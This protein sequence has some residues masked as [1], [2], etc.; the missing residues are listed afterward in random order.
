MEA[1][2]FFDE[3]D[4]AF[5]VETP[6]GNLHQVDVLVA[7][8]ESES[9]TGQ[10]A[11]DFDVADFFAENPV[12]LA[13]IEFYRR[14]IKLA[15]D[16]VDDAADQFAAAGFEDQFRDAICRRHGRFEIR[17]ALEAMRGVG[18]DTV[19]LRHVAN[20]DRVPP[21]GFDQD[22]SRL[23]GDHGV[24]SAH[25]TGEADGFYGVGNDEIFGCELAFYAV[26]SLQS[27]TGAGLAD[28]QLSSFQ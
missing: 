12:N 18:V 20:G 23:L 11:A 26:E 24:V 16:Y 2:D 21:C 7:C 1:G 28:N 25:D 10:N 6:A 4:F 22:V 15:G 14:L 27:F 13:A 19:A 3:V 5:H 9:K 17:A 8:H